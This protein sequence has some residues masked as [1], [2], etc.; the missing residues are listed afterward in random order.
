MSKNNMLSIKTYPDVYRVQRILANRGYEKSLQ[1]SYLLWKNH[2]LSRS[3][4][5]LRLDD[6]PDERIF[7]YIK[8]EI[9]D[10]EE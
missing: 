9:H 2:S 8:E 3:A 6:L 4:N 7:N 10:E 5:W 1:E